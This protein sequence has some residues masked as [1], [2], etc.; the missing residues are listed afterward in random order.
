VID[1]YQ[2]SNLSPDDFQKIENQ[3]VTT[4]PT[5]GTTINGLVNVNTASREVLVA[6]GMSS[7]EA[8]AVVSARQT[9][10]AISGSNSTA[11]GISW[12]K[13]VLQ[14]PTVDKVGPLLT[15]QTYVVSADVAAVGRLGRGYRRTRFVFD[16]STGTPK[17][18]YRR[19]MSAAGWAL[20]RQE[21]DLLA[22]QRGRP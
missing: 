5:S 21:R 4:L 1:F 22:Q 11:T 6:I 2:R 20:G 14:K 12:L 18:I 17:I 15:G 16:A 7:E 19:N 8:D 9:S 3:L 10:T 13:G